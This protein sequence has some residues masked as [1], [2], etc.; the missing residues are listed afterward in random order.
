MI[1]MTRTS[2]TARWRMVTARSPGA[3]AAIGVFQIIGG[4]DQAMEALG[5]EPV[6]VGGVRLRRFSDIDR[7]VVARPVDGV[8]LLMPHA[9]P[10]V[11][12]KI[13]AWLES[14]GLGRDGVDDPQ[15]V[16]PE[17]SSLIEARMLHALAR[18]SSPLAID[19]LLD[20]PRRWGRAGEGESNDP[21]VLARSAILNRL[22]DPPT[23]VALGPPNIGKSTLLNVLAGRSVSI[24]ADEPGTTR[25]HV[26][27]RLDLAGLVVNYIDTPGIDGSDARDE[28]QHEARELAHA[29][30]TGA[31][32]VLLCADATTDFVNTTARD[33]LRVGLRSD[34]G[35]TSGA[36]LCVSARSG[37]GLERLVRAVRERLIPTQAIGHA[38]VWRFW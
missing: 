14:S 31:D 9:G 3:G 4:I 30:A 12:R 25:D 21:D 22:I 7:G 2:E 13:E 32:L 11:V 5:I 23:V 24:V 36:D 1:T 26:G 33:S 8:L 35:R 20:Q 28:I 34:S 29:A 27:V 16:Y 18:A 38:G 10:A 17:A 15:M 19:L 37:E 6:A